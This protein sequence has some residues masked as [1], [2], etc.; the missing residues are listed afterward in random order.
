[1]ASEQSLLTTSKA[2]PTV[3]PGLKVKMKT[4]L[5]TIATAALAAISCSAE[6]PHHFGNDRH[7]PFEATGLI[8]SLSPE[9]QVTN[10]DGVYY[11][12]MAPSIAPAPTAATAACGLSWDCNPRYG[13]N[14]WTFGAVDFIP[15]AIL[16][17]D[18]TGMYWM[19]APEGTLCDLG[20]YSDDGGTG[21]GLNKNNFTKPTYIKNL[22]NETGQPADPTTPKIWIKI[23]VNGT[24]VFIP[25]YQ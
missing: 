1:M 19:F 23:Q 3:V 13:P 8:V 24:N 5:T 7:N 4:I 14:H 10:I 15:D 22:D 20:G 9:I 6:P 17:D 18:D 16:K 11:L 25:A 21:R 2:C 12:S